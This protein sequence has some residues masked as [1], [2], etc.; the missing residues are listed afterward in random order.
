[1]DREDGWEGGGRK[2]EEETVGDTSRE[3][4]GHRREGALRIAWEQ[5]HGSHSFIHSFS[6][7]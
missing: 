7:C 1:M 3:A 5:E 6:V 2:E 4:L